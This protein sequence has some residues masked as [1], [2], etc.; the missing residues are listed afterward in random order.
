MVCQLC[1]PLK[2]T[3]EQLFACQ[4]TKQFFLQIYTIDLYSLY[5]E[6]L[7]Q[8]PGFKHFPTSVYES[9]R[10]LP[11]LFFDTHLFEQV[12]LRFVCLSIRPHDH[13]RQYSL[14]TTKLTHVNRC[15]PSMFPNENV[16]C[17]CYT[18]SIGP[19]KRNPIHDGRWAI[20]IQREFQ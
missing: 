20:F 1:Y 3:L 17:S 15:H 6:Q 19:F 14:I 10:S 13:F 4:T 18:F 16:I 5:I 12:S 8:T 9:A 7:T 11:S 2:N